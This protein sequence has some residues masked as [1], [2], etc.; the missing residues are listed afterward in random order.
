[1]HT[2]TYFL[3]GLLT[4]VFLDY[5]AKCADPA[6]TILMRQTNDSLVAADPL[7]QVVRRALFGIVVS[8]LH[9]LVL[10]RKR[11]W[12]TMWAVL[13]IVCIVSPF[14]VVPASNADDTPRK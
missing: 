1:L 10:E 14:G 3:V 13:V 4:I 12:L 9:V 8:L 11:G 6:I 2:V 7:F 5:L